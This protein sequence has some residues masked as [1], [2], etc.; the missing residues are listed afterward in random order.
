MYLFYD[1]ET[2]S[3]ARDTDIYEFG[4]VR[5]DDT[6]RVLSSG[7]LFFC[8]PKKEVFATHIHGL[9]KEYLSK[10]APDF[11]KN[12]ATM[13]TLME[14]SVVVGKHNLIFDDYVVSHF[15]HSHVAPN[16]LFR[17]PSRSV[18]IETFM[19]SKY[20]EYAG[21]VGTRKIGTLEQ[22]MEMFGLTN[23]FVMQ[24]MQKFNISLP[25]GRTHLHSAQYDAI[26]T[27]MVAIIA[28]QKYGILL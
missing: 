18:D 17:G 14:N 24:W 27:F 21:L 20:R 7:T 16:T 25:E 9:T 3:T 28:V 11:A 12:L 10:Y 1:I 13:Y 8:Q 19:A 5:T 4:Y 22:Y 2:A 6:L 26:L 23:D 15:L